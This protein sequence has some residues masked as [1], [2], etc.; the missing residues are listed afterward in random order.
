MALVVS[1]I[2]ATGECEA[3]CYHGTEKLPAK[4]L[5]WD[6]CPL[7]SHSV[8]VT[9]EE[10]HDLRSAGWTRRAGRLPICPIH[11]QEGDAAY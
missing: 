6:G 3:Y 5:D 1:T 8:E 10:L 2:Y 4:Y 7:T 9:R 11:R